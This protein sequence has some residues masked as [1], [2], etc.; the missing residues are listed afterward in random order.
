MKSTR[1]PANTIRL[2]RSSTLATLLCLWAGSAAEAGVVPVAQF[3]AAP[4]TWD[5]G[6]TAAWSSVTGGPYNDIWASGNDAVI[7]GTDFAVV[8]I[9]AG[10]VTA[11]N[12]KFVADYL[13]M[14]G[15]PLILTGS[16]PTITVGEFTTELDAE[17]T[18]DIAGSSGLIK[19]GLGGLKLNGNCSF[20]GATEINGGIVTY[21]G[22]LN[23][24][25][26]TSIDVDGA[27]TILRTIATNIKVT[28]GDDSV[29]HSLTVKNGAEFSGFTGITVGASATSNGN[30]ITF[31]GAGTLA[32]VV[33]N[34]G[35][36]K[37]L[38]VGES[39]SNNT[40]TV[41]DGATFNFRKGNGTN[42]QE[43]GYLAGA[44][45]NAMIVTGANSSYVT[46]APLNVGNAGSDNSLTVSAGGYTN[47]QRLAIGGTGS[48][49]SVLID[50]AGSLVRV[51]SGTNG[52]FTV[53]LN[54]SS[55]NSLTIQ[56]GGAG[57][58]QSTR[59]I[60]LFAI[61]AT[62][63]SDNNVVTV[64]GSGS[65]LDLN[66]T[67]LA[68]SLGGQVAGAANTVTDS[69]ASG[70]HLDIFSG[71]S[72][73]LSPVYL[74][75]VN[76][77]I[78]LGNGT[79]VSTLT[80]RTNEAVT[81]VSITPISLVKADS[82]LNINGGEL[83][84]NVDGVLVSGAG[85]VQLNGAAAVSTPF[86]GSEIGAV[87]AGIGSLTKEDAGTLRL[88]TGTNTYSGD[89][90]ISEGTLALDS[91]NPNNESST[92]TIA[93]S[94]ATLELNFVG[95]D[96]VQSLVIGTDPP[97]PDGVYEAI[98]NPGGGTEIPQI[99]GPG[100]LTV[101]T[102]AASAYDTWAVLKGLTG[103]P[104]SGTDPAF[105]AD[106][107]GNGLGNGLEWILGGNPLVSDPSVFPM[108][109]ADGSGL[110]VTFTREEDS[111][112]E[113]VLIIEYGTDL[114]S[115]PKSAT[116]GATSSGPDANG[117]VVTIN[118]VASP[119]AVSV[120]IPASN[121]VGGQLFSRLKATQL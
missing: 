97:M 45:S 82:R 11:H 56:S 38:R 2:L 22:D 120:F 30:S 87:I 119:D 113:A 47:P 55:G 41:S 59:D 52:V 88:L 79:G 81:S 29:P 99:S 1:T 19:A 102:P 43:I 114:N 115:W 26:S 118:T 24:V 63:G 62:D 40:L 95:T 78:N 109:S 94:G 85:Q 117:V 42:S 77:A 57:E 44:D 37:N 98:G 3:G 10:G 13:V 50:G 111:I 93:S 54:A 107:N 80:M 104:G 84:A 116:I 67:K 33:I 51:N 112:G 96:F 23:L 91:V 34:T 83:I 35:G 86:S 6:T 12:V 89:T 64:A 69:T 28:I 65:S 18:S 121:A 92:V 73:I 103:A 76:S 14:Q 5:T 72:A 9:D 68:I 61:G 31:T 74:L 75:G 8:D 66:H 27:S 70:N 46:T 4:L 71:A 48:N 110:T 49:N 100:T 90:T 101:G 36:N 32:Q 106:L 15:G 58:F 105:G 21:V 108:A 7:E 16:S 25:N 39:G 20:S 17:I 53:G 60:R